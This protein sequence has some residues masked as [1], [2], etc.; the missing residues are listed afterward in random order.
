MNEEHG[1]PLTHQLAAAL[2]A[3]KAALGLWAAIVVLTASADDPGSFL[4]QA[5]RRRRTGVGVLLLVLVAVAVV[6]AVGLVTGRTWA[7]VAAYVLEGLAVLLALSRIG[8]RPLAAVVSLALS[9]AILGLVWAGTRPG[10]RAAR[11]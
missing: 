4:G 6:V 1:V 8:S 5:V 2:L 10:F 7:P 3:V 9:G 11:L